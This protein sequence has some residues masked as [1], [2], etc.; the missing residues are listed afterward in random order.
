MA[1]LIKGEQKPKINLSL[2]ESDLIIETC[3]PTVL[4]YKAVKKIKKLKQNFR[5]HLVLV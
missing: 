5:R 1:C 4:C 2:Y 3:E